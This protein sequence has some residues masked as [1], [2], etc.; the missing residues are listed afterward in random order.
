MK[1]QQSYSYLTLAVLIG[2]WSCTSSL[3][4]A[5]NAGEVDDLYGNSGNA[6]VYASNSSDYGS[7]AQKSAPSQR[8]SR[9]QQRSLRN[10]NP[11]YNDE[12]YGTNGT[13]NTD[14][15]YTELSA[16]KLNRGLSADPG[17]NDNGTNAYNSGFVN[18][19]NSATTSAYSWNRWGYNNTGFYSGLGLGLGMGMGLGGYGY[20]SF[21]F[22]FG[23]PY[24]SPF[25]GSYGYSPFYSP[26]GYSS[27]YSPFNSYA[28]G[29]FGGYGSYYSPYYSPFYGNSYGG[30]YGSSYINNNY[31]TGADPYR[32]RTYTRTNDRS[33][34]RYGAAFDNS[35]RTYNPNGGRS[36][37]STANGGTSDG[38]YARPS[39]GSNRG[40]YYYDNGSGSNGRTSAPSTAPSYNSN[41]GSNSDYYARPR[42]SSRGSYTP[43]T[44]N[45]SYSNGGSRSS[46]QPS[47]QQPSYQNNR[48]S[49]QQSQPSFNQPSYSAPSR[50]YST[51]SFSAP[52][53]GGGGFSSGGGGG[54][55]SG[56]GGR[57]PR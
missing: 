3:K 38:Y 25:Y 23:S 9:Q 36:S 27:F 48:G 39:N 37:A 17:W 41:S 29:G 33:A 47:N 21:G 4:T 31:V 7:V 42:E 49:Y 43:S 15:Y 45:N 54:Q 2:L 19:Y 35:P 8:Y 44:G 10:A 12:Q 24:Y 52:S 53:G 40:S 11:D 56:G 1:T 20:N 57:G 26:F 6:A 46:Y 34:G 13:S 22:G 30:Y 14:E 50:S 28:F 5:Q 16:R 18:G 51:P 55:S 32:T